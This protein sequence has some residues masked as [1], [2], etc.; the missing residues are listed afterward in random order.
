MMSAHNP[1]YLDIAWKLGIRYFDTAKVY[2]NGKSEL[3][4][5]EWLQRYPERRE[6]LFLVSKEPAGGGPEELLTSIDQRLERCGTDYLNL[7]LPPRHRHP[8]A[9]GGVAGMAQERP[10]QKGGRPAEGIRQVPDGRV[11]LP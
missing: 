10:V 2:I 4:V 11:L 1:Q 6:E 3:H 9:R 7:Y 5:A 8:R